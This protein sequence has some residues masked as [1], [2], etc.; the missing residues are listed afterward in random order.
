MTGPLVDRHAPYCARYCEEN[1]WHR[2]A[3]PREANSTALVLVISNHQQ[4]VAVF[5]QRAARAP[6]QPMAWDYH[7][8]FA[9]SD[10]SG[11]WVIDVDSTLAIPCRADRYLA[12]SFPILPERLSAYRP[13]FRV[14]DA[15]TYRDRLAT[16]RRH[17]R[18]GRG[19]YLSPPPAWPPI[20]E[21]HNLDRLIDMRD[22]FVGEVVDLDGLRERLGVGIA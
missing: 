22:P 21:G 15:A 17:M 4:R 8:V 11:W 14:V 16:D 10:A 20:G 3:E 18:D 1:V 9:Q 7:V 6:G 5:E 2:C 12:A 13:L 19:L